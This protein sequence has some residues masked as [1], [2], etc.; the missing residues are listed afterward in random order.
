MQ[1][2]I[3]ETKPLCVDLDGTLIASDS[4]Y[5]G[6]FQLVKKK[7]F[8]FFLLPFWLLK[9]RAFLKSRIAENIEFKVDFL[10]YNNEIIEYLQSEKKTGRKII[11]ATAA[12]EILANKIAEK[13]GLFDE[14]I[15]SNGTNNL[16][17]KMKLDVLVERFGNKGYDY[18]GNSLS[19]MHI[20]KGADKVLV[21]ST[22]KNFI[23]EVEKKF[24]IDKLFYKP[25]K[26]L[27]AFVMEIRVYQ[28]LKNLLIFLP[29]LLA[30]TLNPG[31]SVK[32]LFAFISFSLMASC[33]YIINDLVDLEADRKHPT[34]RNRPFARGD[35]SIQGGIF[36]S[37]NFFI[38]SVVT[39]LVFQNV[40]FSFI[41]I[42]YFIL[43][44]VYT[45]YFKKICVFDIIILASLYTIRIIAGGAALDVYL[46]P[47]LLAFSMFVFLSLAILKRFSELKLLSNNNQTI[48]EGRGYTTGD[49]N[50]LLSIGPASG[51]MSVLVFVLYVNSKEV[52]RLYK[53]PELLWAI[54]P[55]ILFWIIRI[56]FLAYRGKVHDDPVVFT[57]KDKRSYIIG[58]FILILVVGAALW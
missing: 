40:Y 21:V 27:Q 41:L 16:F 9:G 13:I 35:L 15:A 23:Q 55:L 32:A 45:F 38:I 50:L 22:K 18:I 24:K 58:L 33:V 49:I 47:W 1:N 43:T 42:F 37:F 52:V 3:L 53:S 29:I 44:T 54:A 51:F 28:W 17:G 34:K 26:Y 46:S 4:L 12:S 10:P 57:I 6:L 31:L 19:D 5:E 30:H 39:S 20:W 56:W 11:L 7:P 48:S 14:V 8:Y 25:V 36:L 2:S